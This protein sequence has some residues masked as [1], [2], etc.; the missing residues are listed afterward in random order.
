[1]SM[2]KYRVSRMP[3]VKA[4]KYVKRFAEDY[5]YGSATKD[6]EG[7]LFYG[8]YYSPESREHRRWIRNQG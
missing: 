4:R 5:G 6:G 8:S 1:M 3:L 2:K 7:K